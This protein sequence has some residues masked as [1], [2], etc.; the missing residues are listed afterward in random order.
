MPVRISAWFAPKLSQNSHHY[1]LQLSTIMALKQFR[2]IC[3]TFD[4]MPKHQ[5]VIFS[6]M[7]PGAPGPISYP[8]LIT[9]T[10]GLLWAFLYYLQIQF[11]SSVLDCTQSWNWR[12][13]GFCCI[14]LWRNRLWSPRESQCSNFGCTF[15]GDLLHA[16]HA[17]LRYPVEC[18]M[19]CTTREWAAFS[20]NKTKHLTLTT[21]KS[22]YL[23]NPS[24]TRLGPRPSVEGM[25]WLLSVSSM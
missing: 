7:L 14:R 20:K 4:R 22:R 12:S 2:N 17:W 6:K 15:G 19:S 1:L 3:I 24:W 16:S 5:F 9:S 10:M 18:R 11:L 21:L 23:G 13:R 8:R 25:C